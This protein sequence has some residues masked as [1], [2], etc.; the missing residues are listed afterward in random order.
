MA[1][2]DLQLILDIMAADGST[3]SSGAIVKFDSQFHIGSLE[4]ITIPKL[5]RSRELFESGYTEVNCLT[6]P[7]SINI[8]VSSEDE[9]N[10]LTVLGLNERVRDY[11]NATFEGLYFEVVTT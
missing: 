3:I 4:I 8:E 6:L 5:Y 7:H 10:Q 1:K 11:L 2:I 9:F